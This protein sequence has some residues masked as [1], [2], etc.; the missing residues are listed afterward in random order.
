MSSTSPRREEKSPRDAADAAVG[1]DDDGL[2]RMV[3]CEKEVTTGYNSSSCIQILGHEKGEREVEKEI[4]TIRC[5]LSLYDDD[6]CRSRNCIS[7]LLSARKNIYT[8]VQEFSKEKRKY[9][10]R[11]KRRRNQRTSGERGGRVNLSRGKGGRREKSRDRELRD[12]KDMIVL[13]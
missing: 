13:N 11:G 6:A 8:G 7:A 1:D 3:V 5:P 9:M 2:E 12:I 4:R 10:R